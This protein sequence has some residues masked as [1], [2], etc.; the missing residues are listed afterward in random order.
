[1]QTGAAVSAFA[2]VIGAAGSARATQVLAGAPS[3]IDFYR[4]LY[5][6]DHPAAT[7]F[8]HAAKAAGLPIHGLRANPTSYHLTAFW[9]DDLY[10]RWRKG[11]AAIAGMTPVHVALY[12][13]LLGQDAGLRLVLRA[14]HLQ[15]AGG[16]IEHRLSGPRSVLA[17]AATLFDVGRDWPR[18]AAEL[19]RLTPARLSD[20]TSLTVSSAAG[21][22][23]REPLVSWVMAPATR[24]SRSSFEKI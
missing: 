15:T 2:A 7:V 3:R 13:Q 10:Y 24:A 23:L 21:S 14:Q 5:D 16:R 17:Q 22:G 8:G 20:T 19:I 12:L 1:M 18:A 9:Y 6:Q 4:V 11:P